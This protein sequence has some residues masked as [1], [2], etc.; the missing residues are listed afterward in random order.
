MT[1]TMRHRMALAVCQKGAPFA[2]VWRDTDSHVV[3]AKQCA[4]CQSIVTRVLQAMKEP[5]PG[6]V[7][8]AFES[9]AFACASK[10]D[11]TEGWKEMIT[12]ALKE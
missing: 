5:S 6:M 4:S 12:F 8:A 3:A 1:M 2:C 10:E 11:I 7:T 9:T